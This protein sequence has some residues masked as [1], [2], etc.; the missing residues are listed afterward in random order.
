MNSILTSVKKSL[1]FDEDY[2]VFDDMIIM[3]IN[4]VFGILQQLGVGPVGGFAVQD[5]AATWSS[6]VSGVPLGNAVR[7][8]MYLKVRGYFDPQTTSF[9]LQASEKLVAEL[10]SRLNILAETDPGL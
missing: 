8:Y 2:T 6:F 9:G 7:S 3:H 5:K 10:E 1:G 4:T